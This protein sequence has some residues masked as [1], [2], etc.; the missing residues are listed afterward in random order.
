MGC[1]ES[2]SLLSLT[3]GERTSRWA[4]ALLQTPA[5]LLRCY[6]FACLAAALFFVAGTAYGLLSGYALPTTAP[7]RLWEPMRLLATYD[8]NAVYVFL[9]LL[10]PYRISLGSIARRHGQIPKVVSAGWICVAGISRKRNA[11]RA[12]VCRKLARRRTPGPASD[13]QSPP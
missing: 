11:G 1:V 6:I 7:I 13:R 5:I 10:V 9:L 12:E 2:S 3:V 4:R 8:Y